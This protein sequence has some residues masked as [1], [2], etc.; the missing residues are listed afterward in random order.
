M[1]PGWHAAERAARD[2]YGR[3]L[4]RLAWRWRDVAAAEDALAA[5]LEAALNAWPRDGVPA[6][7]QAWLARVAERRL[8]DAARHARVAAHPDT[9]RMLSQEREEAA[10]DRRLSLL[11][12]CA[13]PAIDA[14]LHA[15]LMLQTVLGLDSV[16]IAPAFLAPP[17]AMKRRLS[18]P[19]E[20]IRQARIPFELPGEEALPER[21]SAVLEAIYAALSIDNDA[22]GQSLADEAIFL[23]ELVSLHLPGEPQPLGLLALMLHVQARRAA[24]LTQGFTPLAQQDTALWHRALAR[25]CPVRCWRA[26]RAQ[27]GRDRSSWKR[28]SSPPMPHGR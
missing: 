3:L 22:T 28:R 25:Q 26:R 24:R 15:A 1:T 19:K 27:G 7:P 2:A 17:E 4:A 20:K 10:M 5:A 11:L 12:V 16:R 13:H 21:L 18:R 23:A 8:L 9:Q 6:S 14:R